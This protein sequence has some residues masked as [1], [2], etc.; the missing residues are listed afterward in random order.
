MARDERWKGCE[1]TWDRLKWAR[2]QKY[3]TAKDA[4]IAVGVEEGTYRTYERHPDG[5]KH[6]P[7]DYQK[8]VHFGRRFGVRWEWLLE[9][10]GIPWRALDENLDRILLAY[11]STPE[12]RR[13]AVAEAIEQLLKVG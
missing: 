10:T 8:A 5:S 11:E 13:A 6:T 3:A 4:A 7:L 2:L 9:G 12:E 1:G